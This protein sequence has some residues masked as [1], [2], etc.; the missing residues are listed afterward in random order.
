MYIDNTVDFTMAVKRILWGKCIN[1][2]QTC[3]APDYILCT[4]EVQDKFVKEAKKILQEWYSENP[5][6]SPDLA[7][8][9]S[10]KHYKWVSRAAQ[11]RSQFNSR[12]FFYFENVRR[13]NFVK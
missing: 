2:G 13:S 9:I 7:R 10:D 1:A 8:L 12:F 11:R 5:E 3:I 4:P 6:T